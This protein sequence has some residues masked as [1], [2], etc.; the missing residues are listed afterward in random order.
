M[1]GDADRIVDLYE[2]HALAWVGDRGRQ[3]VFF[4]KSWLDRFIAVATPG[5]P[6]LDLGCGPGKPMAAY[7]IGQGLRVHGVDS[8]P[9]MMSLFRENFPEQEMTVGDMRTLSLG[10]R[11]AGVLAWDSFFHL[12]YDDQRRMFPIFRDHAA[13]GAPLLFTSGPRHGEAIG[14][15][16][17]EPLFHASLAPDEYRALLADNGFTVLDARMEDPDCGGHSVWLARRAEDR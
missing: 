8:S 10:R 17:G 14:V 6:V 12:A 9:T 3:K 13:A 11:F 7:L 15:L 16:H 1:T 4:E 2:R 5:A